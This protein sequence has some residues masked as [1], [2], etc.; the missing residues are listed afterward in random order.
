MTLSGL[1]FSRLS[2]SGLRT[3]LS[4]F[5]LTRLAALWLSGLR[6]LGGCLLRIGESLLSVLQLLRGLRNLRRQVT[7]NRRRL[8]G[9]RRATLRTDTL[10]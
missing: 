8:T 1:A 6:L 7:R 2:L 5:A 9:L 10:G 3:G 4:G